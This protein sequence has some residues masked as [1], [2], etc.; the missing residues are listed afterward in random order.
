MRGNQSDFSLLRG[1][2][3]A[4]S[5]INAMLGHL[6][7]FELVAPKGPAS[8][9]LPENAISDES[10]D[11]PKP[12]RNMGS[13]YVQQTV[14]LSEVIDRLSDELETSA[15]TDAQLRMLCTI[16]GIGPDTAGAVTALAPDLDMFDSGSNFA[17]WLSLMPRQ[18]STCGKARPGAVSKMGQDDI[19]G[20]QIV[21]ALRL[22]R[23]AVRKGGS[24]RRW[25]AALVAR[26][27]MTVATVTLA[28]KMARMI[29][30][31]SAKQENYRM[32]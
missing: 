12:V 26:K 24:E 11:L 15:K 1:L 4:R 16:P 13:I 20:L 8:F 9:K 28:N 14:R 2:S 30:T 18:R 19:R 31:H 21:C 27:P 5:I 32:A 23:W 29:G 25:L 17:A 6:A 3:R 22:I 7:E 10:T